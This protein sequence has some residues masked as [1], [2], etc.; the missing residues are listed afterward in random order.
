MVIFP[1]SL[2]KLVAF[3]KQIDLELQGSSFTLDA[4]F[5]SK[6]NKDLIKE[7]KL[8]PVINPNRRNPKEH[9]CTAGLSE[10]TTRSVT[11]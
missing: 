6:T 1:E 2:I 8:V 3:T 9:V 7:H 5:D 10:I 4:G 11:K